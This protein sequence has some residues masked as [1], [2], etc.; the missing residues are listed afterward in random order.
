[1]GKKILSYVVV[2]LYIFNIKFIF[3]P[4]PLRTRMILGLVG[5]LFIFTLGKTAWKDCM[6]VIALNLVY[7]CLCLF[8][9]SINNTT[10]FWFIQYAC[11]N[12]LY[13]IGGYSIGKYMMD[14]MNMSIYDI[15]SLFV[16]VVLIHNVIAFAGFI[17]QPISDF[18][19]RIQDIMATDS[20]MAPIIKFHLRAVGLGVGN[21]F[22]GAVITGLAVITNFYLYLVGKTSIS[23]CI[24]IFFILLLS[25]I[26]IARTTML[27]GIGLLLLLFTVRGKKVFVILSA[28]LLIGILNVGL[29]QSLLESDWNINASWAFEGF[30]EDGREN[31][32]T[33]NH[34]KTMYLLPDNIKTWI[35]GDGLWESDKGY[36]MHTDVGYMR[37]LFY[38]GIGSCIFYQAYTY[39]FI[40]RT[41]SHA[42][43]RK[44]YR[45]VLILF[46][47]LIQMKGFTDIMFFLYLLYPY[48]RNTKTGCKCLT[49][50]FQSR[51]GRL[52]KP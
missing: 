29:F 35:I 25:G 44:A 22:L 36:Y 41:T 42:T 23:R 3:I 38:T 46:F 48:G 14:K 47:L 21:F 9:C 26:F 8:S 18:I 24:L 6:L 37:L 28:S 20:A 11:L 45:L 17:F 33:L 2:F 49:P 7:C 15:L 13:C 31:S 4:G 34:L 16:Y 51:Y 32:K 30:T 40:C 10:D 39:F 27:S 12:I 50:N 5:C 52:H 1:M 43:K 19:L